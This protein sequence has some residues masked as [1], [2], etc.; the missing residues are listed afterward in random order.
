M[1]K[2]LKQQI[3]RVVKDIYVRYLKKN[4]IVYGNHMCL[5]VINHI[6]ANYYKITSEDL[7]L[8]MERMKA[9]HN[10]NETIIYQINTAIDFAAA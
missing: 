5:E 4:Y 3:V 1:E 6:K 9:L 7:K 2:Y 8:N 10:I